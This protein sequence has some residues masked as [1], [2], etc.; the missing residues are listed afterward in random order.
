MEYFSEKMLAGRSVII[1]IIQI[2]LI[3]IIGLLWVIVGN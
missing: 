1:R 3:A 2:M